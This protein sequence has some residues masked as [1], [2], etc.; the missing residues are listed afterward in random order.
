MSAAREF[1]EHVEL[2][3]IRPARVSASLEDGATPRDEIAAV[4]IEVASGH[5]IDEGLYSN[6]FDFRFHLVGDENQPIATI[7][8]DFILDYSVADGYVANPEAA[9]YVSA[10]TGYFAVFP[11]ARELLQSL[12]TS[13]RL[14]PL[15]MG[16][17]K[18]DERG[19]PRPV[20]ISVVRPRV[21]ETADAR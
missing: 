18:R 19:Q 12:A 11:Y 3:D 10:T 13:L 17:L 5:L 21:A 8:F 16:F 14:P 2:Q 4:T 20:S 9:E 7:E 6:R 1:L 15:V